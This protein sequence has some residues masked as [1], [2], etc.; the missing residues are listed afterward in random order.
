MKKR[1]LEAKFQTWFGKILMDNPDRFTQ[2]AAFELKQ[3]KGGTYNVKQWC[4]KQPHQVR[5]CLEANSRKGVY[6]KLSDLD[7][8]AK[9]FDCVLFRNSPAFLVIYWE[10]YNDWTMIAMGNV[11][12][13]FEKSITYNEA[14]KLHEQKY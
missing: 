10:K 2:G 4:K 6:F 13:F 12:P 1:K 8:R 9:P 7:P 5:G 11:L 14:L 3:T